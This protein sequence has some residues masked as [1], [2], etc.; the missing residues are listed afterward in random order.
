MILRS[1][2]VE[3]VIQ[4]Y[5]PKYKGENCYKLHSRIRDSFAGVSKHVIQEWIN[6]NRKH[7]ENHPIFENKDPPQPIIAK[8]P[9]DVCQI[10]LMIMEKRPSKRCNNKTYFYVLHVMDVFSQYIFL[11]PL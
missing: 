6:F 3:K 10:D 8:S 9:M 4:Y 5:F 11:K 1:S 2:E 7:C